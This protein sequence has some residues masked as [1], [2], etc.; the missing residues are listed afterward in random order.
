MRK[1]G[2]EF[3]D[4]LY[5]EEVCEK[6]LHSQREMNGIGTLSEKTTHAV[7]KNYMEPD[8]RCHEI[9]VAGYVADILTRDNDIIE[10]QTRAFERLRGK[11]KAFLEEHSVTVVYPLPATKWLMWINKETGEVSEPRK[12]PKRGNPYDIFPEL[13]KI[14]FFLK[15]HNLHFQILMMDM[16][17]YKYLDGWSIDKKKGASKCDRIPIS[18]QNEIIIDSAHDFCI[19][20][21]EN[22]PATFTSKEYAKAAKISVPKAQTALNILHYLEV[23]NR[24]GKDKNAYLYERVTNQIQKKT[25]IKLN[26][27]EKTST[28][29]KKKNGTKEET[30]SKSSVITKVKTADKPSKTE[31]KS[32]KTE[33]KSSKTKGKSSKTEGKTV[34]KEGKTTKTEGKTA[35]KEGETPK[36]KEKTAKKEVKKQKK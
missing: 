21:P 3:M 1:E 32:S 26:A 12:S 22:L 4:P 2:I 23:V 27:N 24:V 16:E 30:T 33:G 29:R 14:K 10:I 9:R 28:T 35:K 34:K 6:I 17:E 5:F 19:F 13:Y 15:H 25:K 20:I 7:I 8:E 31:G 11:L 18:L 36:T